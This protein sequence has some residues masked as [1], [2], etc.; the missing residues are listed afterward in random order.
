MRPDNRGITA[1]FFK[2]FWYIQ[3]SV[4]FQAVETLIKD[5]FRLCISA[6]IYSADK[7]E[8][9]LFILVSLKIIDVNISRVFRVIA[10]FR[11]AS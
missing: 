7:R 6:L 8:R 2:P 1:V 9:N 4:N 3:K 10:N 5:V 11:T